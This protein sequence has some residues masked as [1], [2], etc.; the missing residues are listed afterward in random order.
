MCLDGVHHLEGVLTPQGTFRVYLYDAFTRPV[1]PDEIK[2]ASGYVEVGETSNPPR[3]ALE[4][5]KDQTTM[6]GQIGKD[7][8]FPLTL[9][10]F[11]HLPGSAPDAKPELFTFEFNRY[12]VVTN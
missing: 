5:S 3:V 10:L 7:V 6:E 12:S 8:G 4:L 9:T 2:E 11:L 1:L